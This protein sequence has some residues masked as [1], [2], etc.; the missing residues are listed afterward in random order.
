MA[1]MQVFVT[2]VPDVELD[3]HRTV[4]IPDRVESFEDATRLKNDALGGIAL[5]VRFASINP[6]RLS[7]LSGAL[8][9]LAAGEIASLRITTP[10]DV[11]PLLLMAD[12][13][14]AEALE[15]A[16]AAGTLELLVKPTG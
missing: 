8:K 12:G 14:E 16:M 4:R 2:D 3:G 10:L 5:V 15:R 9:R 7:I 6:L 11:S 13:A 1:H